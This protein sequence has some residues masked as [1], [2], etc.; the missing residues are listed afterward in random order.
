[1]RAAGLPALTL[2]PISS[3]FTAL[4]LRLLTCEMGITIPLTS[5]L[6]RGL[7]SSSWVTALEQGLTQT[8]PPMLLLWPDVHGLDI[9]SWSHEGSMSISGESDE[10]RT[11]IGAEGEG[12]GGER[13]TA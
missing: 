6:P 10:D 13:G 9:S 4:G 12:K 8:R 3:D 11:E 1:M 7:L 2:P 5:Q